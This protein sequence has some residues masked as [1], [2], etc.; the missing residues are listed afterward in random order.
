VWT[1]LVLCLVACLYASILR[2]LVMQWWTDPD[3]GHGFFVPLFAAFVLWRRRAGILATEICPHNFGLVVTAVSICLLFL[4]SLGAE[5]FIS[6][7]SLL[8]LCVGLILFHR[9]W[10]LLQAVS[11]PLA[12]MILMIPIPAILYNEITFPL[13]LV[14][15]RLASA[16]LELLHVAVFR[17]GNVLLMSNYSLQVVEAC[18]GIRSLLSL[19]TLAIAYGYLT[20]HRA[21]V[22]C[23]L[24]AAMVP[25][26]IVTNALRVVIAG[27]SAHRFGPAAAAGFLHEFSG[28]LV[29]VAALVLLVLV[30]SVLRL[31]GKQG[32]INA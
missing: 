2:G 12:F 31:L 14:A 32:T 18:S 9:G 25:S 21:W 10:R 27:V 22:R 11:F 13:Q 16:W 20:D 17:E 7:V 28:W 15:S 8:V 30:H 4:G 6:R 19:V 1:I 3:Y 26:A 24:A 23:V 5:L 29:F